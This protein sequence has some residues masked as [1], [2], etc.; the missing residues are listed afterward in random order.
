MSADVSKKE[1]LQYIRAKINQLLEIMGTLPLR[2]EELD[3]GMLVELDPIGTIADSFK[4][5][6]L[7]LNETNQ[8]LN[9]ATG[10]IRAIFDTL[11]AA[12]LV[13]DL[14]DRIEDCNRIALDWFFR[15][16]DR[17]Q[18]VG[19]PAREV[20]SCADEME[21]IRN[22][23]DGRI[24]Y[25]TLPDRDLQIVA[26]RIVD[27]RGMHVRTVMLFSDI[28]LQK[29]TERNLG[30]YSRVFS[31]VG[32]G[33]IIA[34]AETQIL[35][36]NA[37]VTRLTGFSREELVGSKTNFLK[38]GLHEPA[39]YTGMWAQLHSQDYWQGEILDRTRDGRVIPLLQTISAVR[40]DDGRV[41]HYISVMADISSIKETQNR[42]D[43][44]AHHDV[45]TDLPNRLLFGDRL[46]H[47]IDRVRR[48]G[49]QLA[50]L[51]IDLDR[52]KTINDSLGHH[53]GDRLLVDAS[54][55]L[56]SLI[57]RADTVARLG[58]DEFVVLMENNTSHAAAARLADKI[59]AAFKQPFS[60]AGSD[61]HIGCSI[62]ITVFPEDGADAVTLLK[63]ADAAMYRAKEAGRD[64]HYRY[65]AELSATMHA[66]LE[67]DAALRRAV[68]NG[69]FELYFQPIFD[70]SCADV[71]ACEALI[72]W[73]A[74][75]DQ[76]R[77]PDV[78]IPQAEENRLI[79]PLGDWIL[80]EALTCM[81]SWRADGLALEY[82]S[83]NISMVQL[84]E[85]DFMARV[86]EALNESGTSGNSLQIE[87]TE[88]VLMADADLCSRV[89]DQ[90]RE[91][92]IRIA[93]DDFGTG[94]SSL[95][96]LKQL[97][98]DILKIDRSFVEGI[99]GDRNDCA[100][101]AAVISM[102]KSL[103]LAVVAE[104]V[105]TQ[106]QHR[107]LAENGCNKLQGYLFSRPLPAREFVSFVQGR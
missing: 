56:K 40:D 17:A 30:L 51:F 49:G 46:G 92:G 59:I 98:I 3:D 13:L 18:I 75:P 60:V 57:R 22:A 38:S 26:S 41:S 70:I 97:P 42:L 28:T 85:P 39:F 16:A 11:G 73:P 19:Q 12:V 90:L 2:P 33:I 81:Q 100:I 50:L 48:D 52:F 53:I 102:A 10:E 4:Q 74:G 6:I 104:G 64:G 87:L 83:V 84:A 99:P 82:V 89:L 101:A 79:V 103:G 15:G 71:V 69:E 44:L 14:D 94:Y 7:H 68:R 77:T 106:D 76:G 32:E 47:A 95:A 80:R 1:A 61:L 43:Y 9:V 91:L 55:R 34:D 86:V 65:S 29:R 21:S 45:L 96:Y 62:G 23:A 20:C 93:I 66:K 27:E 72:R 78:F 88:N 107:Y 105:E 5:V 24:H 35:E 58:G 36:V 8:Q 67:L 63:N 37:A 54:F 25:A 31:H